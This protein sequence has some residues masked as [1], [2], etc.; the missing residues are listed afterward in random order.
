MNRSDDS[1]LGRQ[2]ERTSASVSP[3]RHRHPAVLKRVTRPA[4]YWQHVRANGPDS[5]ARRL[6]PVYRTIVAVDIEGS[7]AR[8]DVAKARLRAV[9]YDLLEAALYACGIAEKHRDPLVD[10]GDGA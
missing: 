3:E 1:E 9:L 2:H 10:R 8:T 6:S 7:T 5:A 4:H